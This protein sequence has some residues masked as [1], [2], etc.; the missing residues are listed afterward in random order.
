MQIKISSIDT[1]LAAFYRGVKRFPFVALFSLLLTIVW[2]G[3]NHDAFGMKEAMWRVMAVLSLGIPLFFGIK[4]FSESNQLKQWNDAKKVPLNFIFPLLGLVFLT[5]FYFLYRDTSNQTF[6]FKYLLYLLSVHLF[7][8]VSRFHG[9]DEV[10]G[11][12]QLNKSLF[13]QFFITSIYSSVLAIGLS[14]SLG[15]IVTLFKVSGMNKFFGDI[16][17]FSMGFFHVLHFI[18][19]FTDDIPALQTSKNYPK[20]LKVF[21]QYLLIPLISFYALILYSY[22][23]KIL[24][25]WELPKGKIAIMISLMAVL[26]I[27]NLLLLHPKREEEESKW[28]QHYSK[29]FYLALLPLI[30]LLLVSILTRL[31]QYGITEGRYYVF[32]IAIW[33]SAISLYFLLSKSKEI[34]VI[35]YSLLV[36]ALLST[37]GPWGATSLSLKSQFSRLENEL[38]R[39]GLLSGDTVN[40]MPVDLTQP[41]FS[42][43]EDIL[44]YTFKN[45]GIEAFMGWSNVKGQKLDST[46]DYKKLIDFLQVEKV[47]TNTWDYRDSSMHIDREDYYYSFDLPRYLDI[48]RFDYFASISAYNKAKI[49]VIKELNIKVKLLN[50][51]YLIFF[52][53]EEELGKY[54]LSILFK[55]LKEAQVLK[56]TRDWNID[57]KLGEFVM[58]INGFKLLIHVKDI[59]GRLLNM[60]RTIESMECHIYIQELKP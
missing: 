22:E 39:I 19:N 27:I 8:A 36:A 40:E 42:K 55:R 58:Q 1:I 33:L 21:T 9:K 52:R 43:A 60:T 25:S 51:K 44:R 3:I 38:T 28:I 13:I 41:G 34:R 15:S 29:F 57:P 16:W 32:L 31:E 37:F 10:N 59:K 49:D 54:D 2:S 50:E 46:A 45:H 20:G 53:D 56:R 24:F 6:T 47:L 26:G 35:P 18:S 17:I 7:V 11:F 48:K 23:L 12:W 4:L 14:L 5:C 30:A